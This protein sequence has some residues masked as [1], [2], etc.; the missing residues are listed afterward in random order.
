MLKQVMTQVPVLVIFDPSKKVTVHT[1]ASHLAIGAVLV[2]D[3]PPVAFLSCK[4]SSAEINYQI[5]EKEQLAV[6]YAL[7][8]WRMYLHSTTEPFTVFT[9]HQSLTH[10]DV[11]N[12]L[13]PQQI[14][15]MEKLA[16][17]NFEIQYRKGSLN[18]VPDA[19]SRRPDYQLST[20]VESV[21]SV[22]A[23]LLSLCREEIP[24]DEYF[25]IFFFE[26]PK[27]PMLTTRSSV[28]SR[29]V[30]CSSKRVIE[31]A[32]LTYHRSRPCC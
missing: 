11:K 4:L 19:L 25:R 7:Q 3:G 21:P 12:T 1:D 23:E 8:K 15:W 30:S 22:G 5:H 17:Y 32:F 31:S 28:K 10:L 9:D 6:V 29:M 16:E 20:I 2:Q 13:S 18:V 14:R 27:L 26:S 24:K